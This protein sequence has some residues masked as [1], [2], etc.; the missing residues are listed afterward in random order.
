VE[1]RY[2]AQLARST[3]VLDDVDRA[4]ERLSD[5]AYGNCETCAAP[6]LAADLAADPTRRVCEQHLA[7]DPTTP[8]PTTA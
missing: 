4:L 7:L 8:D 2:E 5:G 6:I 3:R 1:E